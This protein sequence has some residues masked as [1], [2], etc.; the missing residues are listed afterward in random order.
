MGLWSFWQRLG[1]VLELGER[2]LREAV[3]TLP[4]ADSFERHLAFRWEVERGSGRLVPIESPATFDLDDLIGVDAAVARLV[5]NVEQ[6]VRGSRLCARYS[7]ETAKNSR[8]V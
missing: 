6:F 8:S 1:R 5:A 4:D 3:G 2:V 7:R